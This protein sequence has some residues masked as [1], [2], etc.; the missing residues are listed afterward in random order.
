MGERLPEHC[1]SNCYI[2]S[3]MAYNY[4]HS[5][6]CCIPKT[7][8]RDFSDL[9]NTFMVADTEGYPDMTA[10]RFGFQLFSVIANDDCITVESSPIVIDDLT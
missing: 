2:L 6:E 1:W 3:F 5:G 10:T 9:M 7:A 8:A 4:G